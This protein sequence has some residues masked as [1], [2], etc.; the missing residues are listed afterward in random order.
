MQRFLEEHGE[1]G[2]GLQGLIGLPGRPDAGD[3]GED[4]PTRAA[5]ER[6]RHEHVTRI[7]FVVDDR[8]RGT[9]QS[10]ELPLLVGHRNHLRSLHLC[11]ENAAALT[12]KE[13]F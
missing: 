2:E 8:Q 7:G 6:D 1:G 4:P 10:E 3:A 9:V 5:R 12:L 11:V 13:T